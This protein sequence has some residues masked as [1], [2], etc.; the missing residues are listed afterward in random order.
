MPPGENS[1]LFNPVSRFDSNFIGG[2]QLLFNNTGESWLRPPEL[3]QAYHAVL[4][5]FSPDV[6]LVRTVTD[7]ITRDAL[8]IPVYESG[9]G[10]ATRSYV[11][12]RFNE[13]NFIPFWNSEDAWLNK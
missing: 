3:M 2:L 12:A 4:T 8:L 1:L 13:R 7:M 5:S 6:Q 10:K 11:V 9:I